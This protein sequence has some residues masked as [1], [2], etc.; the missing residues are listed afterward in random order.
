MYLLSYKRLKHSSHKIIFYSTRRYLFPVYY[1]R[2]SDRCWLL[3]FMRVIKKEN[4][5]P[6]SISLALGIV[7]NC[8]KDQTKHTQLEPSQDQAIWPT[9]PPT[10]DN[11]SPIMKLMTHQNVSLTLEI[12]A[13]C[14]RKQGDG[15]IGTKALV[16]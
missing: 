12:V 3:F 15:T 5:Q 8:L 7:K 10:L 2:S 11:N 13:D 1:A 14:R 6:F 9:R 4:L 16:S